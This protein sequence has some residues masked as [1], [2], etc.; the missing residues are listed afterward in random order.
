MEG[1]GHGDE[2]LGIPGHAG[3]SEPS[4]RFQ[5]FLAEAGCSFE[6]EGDTTRLVLGGSIVE[7][8]DEPGG[9]VVVEASI[10]LPTSSTELEAEREGCLKALELLT[11]LG[12][13]PTYLVDASLPGY[14]VLRGKVEFKSLEEA[15]NALYEAVLERG[16]K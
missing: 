12:K 13:E 16:C 2:E 11:S 3:K 8:K 9:G 4:K 7:V 6:A 1:H 10:P 15:Y 5:R 14:P